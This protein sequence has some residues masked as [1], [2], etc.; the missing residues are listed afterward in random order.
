MVAGGF[1]GVFKNMTAGGHQT[2]RTWIYD[3]QQWKETA[4]MKIGRDRPACSLVNMH[5]GKIN[6][7]VAG[8]CD[9]WCAEKPPIKDVQMYNVETNEWQKV[10]DLPIALSSAKME[11]L[12]G[13][14]TIIGGYNQEAGTQN[15]ILY[16]YFVETDDWQAHT[17]QMRMPRSSAAVF[18][19]PRNFF[20]C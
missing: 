6:V 7:L 18:Q 4:E 13:R 11:L 1:V 12:G 17:I 2:N 10:A 8:G 20:R 14:P 5:D 3:G 16:Q 9:G 15:G 19:V